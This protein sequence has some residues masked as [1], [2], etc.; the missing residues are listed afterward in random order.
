MEKAAGV[1]S[2]VEGRRKARTGLTPTAFDHSAQGWREARAPTLG[3]KKNAAN[4]EGVASTANDREHDST[5]SE[6]ARSFDADPG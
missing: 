5:P 2:T 1:D 4:S 6:L 3:T